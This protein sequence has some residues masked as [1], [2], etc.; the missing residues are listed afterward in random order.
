MFLHN[1]DI[2][3]DEVFFSSNEEGSLPSNIRLSVPQLN[4]DALGSARNKHLA[5]Q[6]ASQ[7]LLKVNNLNEF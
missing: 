4:I 5:K 7:N 6:L 1:K 3:L 2:K